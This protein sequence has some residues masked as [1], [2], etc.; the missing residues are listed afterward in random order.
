MSAVCVTCGTQFP[1]SRQLPGHCP[2]CEDE[3]QFLG[4]H[5]Q[6]W[7]DLEALRTS[8]RNLISEEESGL[9]SFFTEPNFAIGQRAFLV[10]TPEGNLLWDCITLLDE[11]TR[12]FITGRGGLRAI[13]ISHPHYYTSVVEWSHAF[14]GIPIYLHQADREWVMRPDPAIEFWSGE[15][16]PLFGG[17]GLYRCG[18]HFAGGAILYWPEGASGKGALLTGDVIQV[19]SD[20]RWVSFMYSYPNYI[21]LDAGA[22]QHIVGVVRPLAFD[23]VYGAF[24]AR[25][26]EHGAKSAIERSAARYLRRIGSVT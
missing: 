20:R 15:V 2:I 24:P 14:G 9:H 26:V 25:T 4:F 5:G 11:A 23:R 12:G 17:L 10:E 1:E 7:T 21:P 6:Q 18:G 13:A 16:R 3:R 8:H 22:V 19:A